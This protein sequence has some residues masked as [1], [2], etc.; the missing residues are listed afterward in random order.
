[1]PDQPNPLQVTTQGANPFGFQVV[2]PAQMYGPFT[3]A[4]TQPPPGPPAPAPATVSGYGGKGEALAM[5]V[6]KF[7]QGA[8]EARRKAF[9]QSEATKLEHAQN[10]DSVLNHIMQGP[11]TQEAKQAA[12]QQWATTRFGDIQNQMSGGGQGKG[13]KGGGGGK[14]GAE[15]ENPLLHFAKG[16]VGS[17][18]GPTQN[19]KHPDFGPE[20][21]NGLLKIANDP[22]SQINLPK[23]LD[24]ASTSL[25]T[26]I[27]S[28]QDEAQKRGVTLDRST[29]M[30]AP[31]VQQAFS[32]AAN[33]G[34]DLMHFPQ[35][36]SIIEGVE[37]KMTT[38]Q[39][40]ELDRAR[41]QTKQAETATAATQQQIN[42]R[43]PMTV[44]KSGP[45]GPET[46]T[47]VDRDAQGHLYKTGTNDPYTLPE[48]HAMSPASATYFTS[49]M[50]AQTA[51]NRIKSQEDME[52][53]RERS[54]ETIARFTQGKLDQR[55]YAGIDMKSDVEKVKNFSSLLERRG[56]VAKGTTRNAADRKRVDDSLK[57]LDQEI[58]EQQGEA[59][60]AMQR[61]QS[62]EA[63]TEAPPG[64]EKPKPKASAAP[65]QQ[66]AD[67]LIRDLLKPPA[68]TAAPPR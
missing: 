41:A 68:A 4:L 60:K 7:L 11:Y 46:V 29:V 36:A 6:S 27:K 54:R 12:F 38:E 64:T 35:I 67:D 50:A 62:A 15:H 48:G 56:M 40:A 5:F 14:A 39:Q 32:K 65:A 13:G 23:M 16:V 59:D 19:A 21:V 25:T 58:Q 31:S 43:T 26:S 61:L 9:E 42:E 28:L 30:A 33:N 51:Q 1:M 34:I 55:F 44:F 18:L 2:N 24:E 37:P 22:N 66:S 53:W 57:L 17:V 52:R 47:T 49:Q 3:E 63:P 45:N 20:A 8:Q 10:Y